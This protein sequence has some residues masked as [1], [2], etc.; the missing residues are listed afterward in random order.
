MGILKFRFDGFSHTAE[1]I[2]HDKSIVSF[3]CNSHFEYDDLCE[4]LLQPNQYQK[5]I[6]FAKNYDFIV[7]KRRYLKAI[8]FTKSNMWNKK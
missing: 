3:K 7:S 1:Y 6:V 2:G 4:I 8:E 5:H